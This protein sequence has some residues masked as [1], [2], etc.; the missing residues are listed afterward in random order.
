MLHELEG[1]HSISTL[2]ALEHWLASAPRTS[3]G[4]TRFVHPLPRD[5]RL[6]I[7]DKPGVYRFLGPQAE[8]IYVGKAT[9]LHTRVNSYFRTRARMPAHKQELITRAHDVEYTVTGSALEAAL[10]ESDEIKRHDPVCNV[11]GRTDGRCVAWATSDLMGYSPVQDDEHVIGPLPRQ[12]TRA[13]LLAAGCND[14]SKLLDRSHA[15]MPPVDVFTTGHECFRSRYKTENVSDL[16]RVGNRLWTAR[17]AACNQDEVSED[18]T[19]VVPVH[20]WSEESVCAAL[21]EIVINASRAIRRAFWF[22]QLQGAQLQ[23]VMPGNASCHRVE[24][25]YMFPGDLPD[26]AP[27]DR[28]AVL[29]AEIRRIVREGAPI[30]LVLSDNTCLDQDHLAAALAWI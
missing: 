16:L 6:S 29:T 4:I 14:A 8:I 21:E 9:S 3:P 2:C 22:T 25:P 23:W 30:S 17:F 10:L 20:G 28:M 24:I 19:D 1:E 5:K 11:A 7:P 18:L 26:I 27:Y 13:G 15:H 12:L